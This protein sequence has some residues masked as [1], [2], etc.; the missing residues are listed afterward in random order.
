MV[1]C[2]GDRPGLWR[3]EEGCIPQAMKLVN[4]GPMIFCVFEKNGIMNAE[5]IR[6]LVVETALYV[7]C[8]KK[9]WI[10]SIAYTGGCAF[11]AEYKYIW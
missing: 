6:H 10:I 5:Q 8:R 3:V 1:K 2:K 4:L 7:Q 11:L 9:I